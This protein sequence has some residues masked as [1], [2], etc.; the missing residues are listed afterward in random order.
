MQV[1]VSSWW[2][3]GMATVY[4][5]VE[6]AADRLIVSLPFFDFPLS[7]LIFFGFLGMIIPALIAAMSVIALTRMRCGQVFS[8]NQLYNL[9]VISVLLEVPLYWIIAL[10]L[11]PSSASFSEIMEFMGAQDHAEALGFFMIL[12]FLFNLFIAMLLR[13]LA[14][15]ISIWIYFKFAP[16]KNMESA[17]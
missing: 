12:M 14:L 5:L 4:V 16:V 3:L 2:V 11:Y 17:S 13:W 15:R 8:Q 7:F 10:V 1:K 9:A 6:F